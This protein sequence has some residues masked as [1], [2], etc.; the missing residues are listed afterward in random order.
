VK[1]LVVTS[2]Q[3][4]L[5]MVI[6]PVTAPAGTVALIC[7][8]LLTVKLAVTLLLK[9]TAVT[10]VKLLPV[11]VTLEPIAPLVGD[12]ELTVGQVVTVKLCVCTS[13]QPVLLMVSG[14]VTAPVGTVAVICVLLLTVKLAVTLLLKRTV[15]TPVKVLPVMVTVEPT[16]PLVGDNV[17]TVW[18]AE[19]VKLAVWTSAQPVLLM[20]MG[21]VT[22]PT[23]TVAV[24][25]VL[26]LM[27]KLAVTLLLKRTAV[28][29]VKLA[30]VI[31]TVAP[32]AP[33]V[34]VKLLTDGQAVT[35]KLCVCTSVQP[36]LLMVIGPV[37]APAGTVVVICVLLL[38]VKL[39]V[40]LLLKRTAVTPVKLL[41]VM[42]TLLPVAPLVGERELTVGQ[43]V[44]VK[45]CV[46]TS[47]QP[48]LLMVRGPVTAPAGT[49][50]VI[51]VLLLTVKLAAM[52]LL[53]RT[54]VYDAPQKLD[55]HLRCKIAAQ[56]SSNEEATTQN[57]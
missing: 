2:A 57:L 7:V 26:L 6:G 16:A 50:A 5:L 31:V 34:G 46:C 21:P 45:L 38:M 14:P 42:M 17:E 56:R 8:L 22:A 35:V 24:I 41:P 52:V 3:P 43:A 49:V 12:R 28:T 33:L 20:V 19:T 44:T 39:A 18:Q 36:V 27:V 30:P 11:I 1:E 54:A 13:V 37:T 23:G 40:T 55:R 51:C 47:A 29:P 4:V 9:R 25:C 32:T 53:K 10:P 15:V 48:V